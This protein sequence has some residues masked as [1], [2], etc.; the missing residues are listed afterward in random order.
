MTSHRL[1]GPLLR[2]LSPVPHIIDH[3]EGC[4]GC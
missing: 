2:Q 4:D 1:A 3:E